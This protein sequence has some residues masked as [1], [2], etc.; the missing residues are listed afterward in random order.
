M[1][2]KYRSYSSS[3]DSVK[4]ETKIHPV[5]RGVGFVF[6][7]LIPIISYA[8]MEVF[9]QQNDIH[10]WFPITPDMLMKSTDFLAPYINDSLLYVKAVIFLLLLIALYAIFTMI[11]F[12]VTSA[13]GLTARNDPY[14]VP[15]VRHTKRPAKKMIK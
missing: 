9:L 10:G 8:A 6:M 1:G 5:W 7:V 2:S 14:Y 4:K 11:A 3:R 15:P 13:S 12:I